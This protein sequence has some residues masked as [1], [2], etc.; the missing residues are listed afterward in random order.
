MQAEL[1]GGAAVSLD[2]PAGVAE[3]FK[4]VNA[5]HRIEV[6]GGAG[7]WRHRRRGGGKDLRLDAKLRS[8]RQDQGAL[9]QIL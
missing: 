8:R 2:D 1:P 4:D 6:L 5:L 7:R 9:D 3:R